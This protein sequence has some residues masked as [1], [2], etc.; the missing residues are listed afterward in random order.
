[1]FVKKEMPE[2]CAEYQR[3]IERAMKGK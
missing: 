2:Y 1:V 3:I